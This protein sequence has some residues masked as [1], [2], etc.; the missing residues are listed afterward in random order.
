M[1]FETAKPLPAGAYM[2]QA[3]FRVRNNRIPTRSQ[4]TIVVPEP[5]L[6]KSKESTQ[7]NDTSILSS[8]KSNSIAVGDNK[9][10]YVGLK[11]LKQASKARQTLNLANYG[12]KQQTRNKNIGP[13]NYGE[14]LPVQVDSKQLMTSFGRI[15]PGAGR[16]QTLSKGLYTVGS[17]SQEQIRPI[18]SAEGTLR[19]NLKANL[20]QM[21]K[22]FK[23]GNRAQ[24][25]TNLNMLV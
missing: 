24:K 6:G 25:G 8:F 10:R 13:L 15:P 5:V 20:A 4:T 14:T 17:H 2:T 18:N 7:Q 12:A 22:N 1:N 9:P 16:T 3:S 21:R 23:N 11:E 19:A